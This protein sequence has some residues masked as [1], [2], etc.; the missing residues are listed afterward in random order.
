MENYSTSQSHLAHL[1]G[2]ATGHI[3]IYQEW[4]LWLLPVL[5][6]YGLLASLLR[7]RRV[8]SMKKRFGYTTRACF[9]RMTD[10]DAYL[11]QQNISELEFPFTFEKAFQFALFRTYGIPSISKLLVATS[12]LSDVKTALKRYADT[13]VLLT[14]FM[15]NEPA[16]ERTQDA[17]ARMNYIHSVYQ[18]AGKISNDDMLYTLSLLAAEPVRW[19]ERYEWRSLQDFE[20]C[21][22]GTFWKSVGD[23]MKI[24]YGRL[25]SCDPGWIDGLQWLEE[26]MA[27]SEAYE[28]RAM[29]PDVNNKKTAD[30]TTAILLW[31]VP[32]ALKEFGRNVVSALMDDRLRMAMMYVRSH[33]PRVIAK[34][35]GKL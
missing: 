16:H 9:T 35:G 34:L 10:H 28:K 27:W 23:A 18:K 14:E 25:E 8:E 4:K 21:A 7:F 1:E 15:A 33:H 24:D 32:A 5:L 6:A 31:T 2:V 12:Q 26:I 20:M 17:M 11:I 3:S 13:E 29:V 19:I 30:E 22:L